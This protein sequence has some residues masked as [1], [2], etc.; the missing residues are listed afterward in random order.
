MNVEI[1]QPQATG[2][3]GL[4]Q[5]IG[6]AAAEAAAR[7]VCGDIL[8]PGKNLNGFSKLKSEWREGRRAAGRREGIEGRRTSE[9]RNKKE[10]GRRDSFEGDKSK[11]RSRKEIF[12]SDPNP[13]GGRADVDGCLLCLSS[14]SFRVG[15]FTAL[16]GCISNLAV[17]RP[18]TA[19]SV[20]FVPPSMMWMQACIQSSQPR[21]HTRQQKPIHPS[22]SPPKIIAGDLGASGELSR[23]LQ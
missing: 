5:G 13:L 23:R 11:P 17:H 20:E 22:P 8:N 3:C 6:S 16:V 12:Q 9:R 19:I 15:H 18:T 1:S 10:S 2:K 7:P 14:L 4:G 21:T